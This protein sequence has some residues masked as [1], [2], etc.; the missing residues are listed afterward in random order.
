LSGEK[1]QGTQGNRGSQF[2]N[3][4]RYFIDQS[5]SFSRFRFPGVNYGNNRLIRLAKLIQS[6]IEIGCR[7]ADMVPSC[8]FPLLSLI[9]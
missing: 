4:K 9:R 7:Y 2:V 1:H 5:L 8:L 6:G 3:I